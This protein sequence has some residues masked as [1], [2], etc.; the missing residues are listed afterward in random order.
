M[1]SAEVISAQQLFSFRELAMYYEHKEKKYEEAKKITE[2][3]LVLSFGTSSYFENDFRHRLDRLN[4]K[5]R[6]QKETK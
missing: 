6:K 3:G 1:A 2:E 5:I 4:Q